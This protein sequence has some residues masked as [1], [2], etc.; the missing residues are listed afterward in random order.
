MSKNVEFVIENFRVDLF[1]DEAFSITKTIEDITNLG[2]KATSFTQEITLPASENNNKVFTNLYDVNVDAGFNPISKKRAILYVDSQPIMKGYLQLLSINIADDQ[3]VGYQCVI[4]EDQT[5]LINAISE[6]N[7]DNL[8]IPLTGSTTEFIDGAELTEFEITGITNTYLAQRPDLSQTHKGINYTGVTFTTG[9][10]GS[11]TQQARLNTNLSRGSSW[12]T[13]MGAYTA[14]QPQ[15]VVMNFAFNF[16]NDNT[17]DFF[18]RVV[19]SDFDVPSGFVDEVIAF[20][21]RETTQPRLI[22]NSPHILN[23]TLDN[24]EVYLNTNDKVRFELFCKDSDNTNLFTISGVAPKISGKIFDVTVNT[25]NDFTINAKE[26]FKNIE[27]VNDSDDA[28]IAFPLVAYNDEYT[29]FNERDNQGNTTILPL[30][31][32]IN[33]MRPGVFVKRI[34]D[35]IFHQA[36]YKY[37]SNFLN[38][39]EFKRLLMIGGQSEE[40][41][42]TLVLHTI[43]NQ[44]SGSI[45]FNLKNTQDTEEFNS[46]GTV[47][48]YNYKHVHLTNYFD[49]NKPFETLVDLSEFTTFN[50]STRVRNSRMHKVTYKSNNDLQDY[51][52]Y[53]MDRNLPNYGYFPTAGTKGKYRLHTKLKFQSTAAQNVSTSVSY[54]YE[55][56]FK[57]IIQKL[58]IGSYKYFPDSNTAPT[59]DRWVNLYEQDVRRTTNTSLQTHQLEIDENF[60]LQQGDML[61]VIIAGDAS[62]QGFPEKNISNIITIDPNQND[63]FVK[64]YKL[65]SLFNG[66]IT[67]LSQLLPRDKSQSEF[68]KDIATL[69]NLYFDVDPIDE[70]TLLIEPRDIYYQLGKV[71]N[72]EKKIDYS[73]PQNIEILSHNLPKIQNFKYTDDEEDYYSTKYKTITNNGMVFGSYKFQSPNEYVTEENTLESS[74]AP[75]YLRRVGD[76]QVY[77]TTII[78]DELKNKNDNE[79]DVP[80]D[81]QPRILSY[82]KIALTDDNYVIRLVPQRTGNGYIPLD[83]K[84]VQVNNPIYQLNNYGYGGHLNDPFTP[85]FDL[86]FFTDFDYLPTTGSTNA[87]LFN[88]FYKNQMIEYTDQ[89]SRKIT[90]SVY[91][92]PTD[93]VNLKLYDTYYFKNAYWRLIQVNNFDTSSDVNQTTEC[94]FIKIVSAFTYDIIQYD[95][96]GYLGING[97]TAT[98]ILGSQESVINTKGGTEELTFNTQEQYFDVIAQQNNIRTDIFD[99]NNPSVLPTNQPK[100][101]PNNDLYRDTGILRAQVTN[102][103]ETLGN[104]DAVVEFLATDYTPGDTINVNTQQKRLFV[105]TTDPNYVNT[106]SEIV[107]PATTD[108]YD[109]YK[110]EVKV[111]E[112][113]SAAF[114]VEYTDN[115]GNNVVLFDT[116]N[117]LVLDNDNI[118]S[119]EFT[120]WETLGKYVPTL[121]DNGGGGVTVNP[122][123]INYFDFSSASSTTF[124]TPATFEPLNMSP[125]V[126][127]DTS[128]FAVDV[129]GIV[130]YSGADTILVKLEGIASG[131]SGA[132]NEIHFA[133]FKNNVLWPCSEQAGIAGIGGRATSIPF[134]CLTELNTN[135]TLQV[136]VKNNSGTTQFN[137]ENIN[138]II[139]KID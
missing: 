123:Y 22:P 14:L 8:V 32:N 83:A 81:I 44:S 95:S 138:V 59:Y 33:A 67:D 117:P 71:I 92:S 30:D 47:N 63:T 79:S 125:T 114:S 103:F 40:E 69:F 127:Y 65:G 21:R 28:P 74:F 121:I 39:N 17:T 132:N 29:F 20:G 122:E 85:T 70:K 102:I 139:T 116:L 34:W 113:C 6:L 27:S 73:K 110:F 120:Y 133:F 52:G 3:F 49:S 38:S 4:F 68:I 53:A 88:L 90:C 77:A 61:R 104:G 98:G 80:F 15:K 37:K 9:T 135:D 131:T 101:N 111:D 78:S 134:H 91:L 36:G 16:T 72:W 48:R 97:G 136:Y 99:P 50:P 130:T 107:L 112:L 5:S 119:I 56:Q 106:P 62:T 35:G 66:T 55:I 124:L 94:I 23:F 46:N 115:D 51:Y 84:G 18:W 57:L 137:L 2:V 19:K 13:T 89:T 105:E 11:I 108:I 128:N 64:F 12:I 26:I 25:S 93:M 43:P 129:S 45:I 96:L 76:S 109:G 58:P 24:I 31:L 100:Y 87:N 7:L 1:P 10:P 126:G 82:K 42:Q 75:S 54:D 41:L 86:N 118:G 60:D